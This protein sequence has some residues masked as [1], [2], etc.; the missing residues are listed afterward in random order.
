MV[1]KRIKRSVC[2]NVCEWWGRVGETVVPH[3]DDGSLDYP[4][5]VF[6][7]INVAGTSLI[8]YNI[9]PGDSLVVTGFYPAGISYAGAYKKIL[10]NKLKLTVIPK[11]AYDHLPIGSEYDD[12]PTDSP[13]DETTN[14]T[15]E[16][17][18]WDCN[19]TAVTGARKGHICLAEGD[20]LYFGNVHYTPNEE[21]VWLVSSKYVD[22]YGEATT[23]YNKAYAR[24]IFRTPYYEVS[25]DSQ[26][27]ICLCHALHRV[28]DAEK[29]AIEDA[30]VQTVSN[31]LTSAKSS[32]VTGVTTKET[33]IPVPTSGTVALTAT[34][35]MTLELSD[36]SAQGSI[37]IV[38]DITSSGGA[39]AVETKYLTG[40]FSGTETTAN[41]AFSTQNFNAISS[42]TTTK[43]DR[44]TNVTIAQS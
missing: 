1:T 39:L 29:K 15:L 41:V 20:R 9:K 4:F 21:G 6:S 42:V 7:C 14:P 31:K 22:V 35:S 2:A 5:T 34:G 27:R 23:D 43:A 40:T 17:V 38:T 11:Y 12:A 8:S 26:Y 18:L 32:T 30:S 25:E 24:I 19:L 13:Y 44:V 36:E 37:P 3:S 16:S 28:S 10:K 33:T